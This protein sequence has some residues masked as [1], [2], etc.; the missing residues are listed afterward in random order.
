[1]TEEL[2]LQDL[3]EKRILSEIVLPLINPQRNGM[4]AGDDCAVIKFGID[5]FVCISTDRVPSDLISFKLGIID[6]YG[7][8]YYLAVL[9]ISDIAASGATPMGLL[10]NFA[11]P[12]S[13]SIT[14]FKNIFYGV[15]KACEDYKCE[16]LGG[17]L[18]NSSE[19]NLVAS[20]IGVCN[21]HKPLYRTGCKVGDIVYC[22]DYIGL[23]PTAFLY[24]LTAK[25]K[26]LILSEKEEDLLKGQFCKPKAR[27]VL[28]KL[29]V[30]INKG[31]AV[32]CM[33]NTDGIFQSLIEICQLNN[34]SMSLTSEK[35]PI[36]EISYKLS[37]M[38]AMNIYDIIF[39]AGADFQLVGTI[40]N[41]VPN[42]MKEELKKENYAEIG[43]VIE[44]THG[45]R[46]ILASTDEQRVLDIPGWNYY[47]ETME[48]R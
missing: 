19:M 26:G 7:L 23:T 18:S 36:H 5:H 2:F 24:F 22:S 31:K 11:F 1:M 15:Q 8:G 10:L 32:T 21:N 3:G 6:Y 25:P 35:L 47:S 17:D 27:T 14:D 16:I 44:N 34:I 28:S 45:N 4:L 37:E 40:N 38:L 30:S 42:T 13:F 46:I 39:A 20:S 29:L 41:N 9:N 33:D 43:I 48:K 12:G